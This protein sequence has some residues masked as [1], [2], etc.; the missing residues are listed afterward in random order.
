MLWVYMIYHGIQAQVEKHLLPSF[1]IV[2]QAWGT[3][4]VWLEIH[5]NVAKN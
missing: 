1:A 5:S 3:D 2:H 4:F